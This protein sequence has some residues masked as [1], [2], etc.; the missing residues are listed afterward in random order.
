MGADSA[1]KVWLD[2]WKYW[3]TTAKMSKEETDFLMQEVLHHAEA[4]NW[5][6]LR[7]YPFVAFEDP[8][9]TWRLRRL[10]Y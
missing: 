7:H 5:D 2:P 10:K 4:G 6:A 1:V 3:S 9:E 8:V